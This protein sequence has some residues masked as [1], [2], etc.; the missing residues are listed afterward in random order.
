V[1]D[2]PPKDVKAFAIKITMDLVIVAKD[3]EELTP[4]LIFGCAREQIKCVGPRL[5]AE[6]LSI[7]RILN[8]KDI[9]DGWDDALPWNDGDA[10][11]YPDAYIPSPLEALAEQAE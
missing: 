6:M 10:D 11:F 4:E 8:K 1:N 3:E 5:E 7:K 2:K 9:P